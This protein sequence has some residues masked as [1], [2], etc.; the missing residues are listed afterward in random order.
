[1]PL[2]LAILAD[3]LKV[4]GID[5]VRVKSHPFALQP[6]PEPGSEQLLTADALYVANFSVGR[7]PQQLL[8]Q[9]DTGSSDLWVPA[10]DSD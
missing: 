2:A 7:P 6:R 3:D 9:L 10:A 5:L 8:L 4:L 1:M